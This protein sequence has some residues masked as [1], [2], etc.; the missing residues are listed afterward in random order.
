M[1]SLVATELSQRTSMKNSEAWSMTRPVTASKLA[2]TDV[3]L[4][5]KASLILS[6]PWQDQHSGQEDRQESTPHCRNQIRSTPDPH[7]WWT[8]LTRG[9]AITPS[10]AWEFRSRHEMVPLEAVQSDKQFVQVPMPYSEGGTMIVNFPNVLTTAINPDTYIK[11]NNAL[12]NQIKNHIK[13]FCFVE[14]R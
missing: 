14:L 10:D 11:A 2:H 5:F 4:A 7:S 13:G 6:K 8:P 3:T 1:W 9:A 12:L